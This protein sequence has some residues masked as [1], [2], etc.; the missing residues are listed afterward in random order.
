M[1]LKKFFLWKKKT[2]GCSILIAFAYGTVEGKLAR[3]SYCI[4][5]FCKILY[6]QVMKIMNY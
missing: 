2:C 6:D 4:V 3:G 1:I 5:K